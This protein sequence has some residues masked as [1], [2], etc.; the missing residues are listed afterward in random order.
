MK[1]ILDKSIDNTFFVAELNLRKYKIFGVEIADRNK[2]M[3]VL[4]SVNE[5][6]IQR[7]FFVESGKNKSYRI[8]MFFRG[9]DIQR[10]S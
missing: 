6:T 10:A 3:K 2:T 9:I 8:R 7:G 1:N 4:C 5:S